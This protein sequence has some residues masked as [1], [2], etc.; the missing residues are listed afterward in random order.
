MD[1][2]QKALVAMAGDGVAFLIEQHD[3]AVL[4][5]ER[6]DAIGVIG[7]DGDAAAGEGN[8]NRPCRRRRW[9]WDEVEPLQ[10]LAVLVVVADEIAAAR[11]IGGEA[12][13]A[14]GERRGERHRSAVSAARS[15]RSKACSAPALPKTGRRV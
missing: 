9:R 6:C 14:G 2:V 15:A 8:Q 1:V 4:V 12:G 5:G 3:E 13:E 11:R 10:V 7:G